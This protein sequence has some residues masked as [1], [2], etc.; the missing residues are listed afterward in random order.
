MDTNP[1][2]C[3]PTCGHPLPVEGLKLTGLKKVIYDYVQRAGAHGI[4]SYRLY[5]LVYAM[6]PNGGPERNCIAVT[7]NQLNKKLKP[8][9]QMIRSGRTGRSVPGQ[10]RLINA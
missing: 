7:I 9:G 1:V 2:K 8:Y 10:Y 6:D 5:D 4:D 3:C